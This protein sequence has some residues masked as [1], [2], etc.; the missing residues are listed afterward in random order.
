MPL[1]P[2]PRVPSRD[3]DAL[4][5]LAQ[6]KASM[7]SAKS[8]AM[9]PREYGNYLRD[10]EQQRL[11][12]K[13]RQSAPTVR[14]NKI[15]MYLAGEPIA[16]PGHYDETTDWLSVNS[17]SVVPRPRSASGSIREIYE[18]LSSPFYLDEPPKKGD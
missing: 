12:R 8:G 2:P 17:I 6:R 15:V 9:G 1:N 14:A 18:K 10:R 3:L 13:V 5:R 11:S 16:H 4:I 7:L